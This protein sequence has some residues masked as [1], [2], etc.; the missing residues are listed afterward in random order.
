MTHKQIA[1]FIFVSLF[2][3]SCGKDQKVHEI[4]ISYPL[5][6]DSEYADYK[7]FTV[8]ALYPENDED[9][10]TNFSLLVFTD[11]DD[12]PEIEKLLQKS[13]MVS[14]EEGFEFSA[15]GSRSLSIVYGIYGSNRYGVSLPVTGL[16]E[17][18]VYHV[19]AMA[20]DITDSAY[21]FYPLATKKTYKTTEFQKRIESIKSEQ[22]EDNFYLFDNG[23]AFLNSS[24][25]FQYDI[26]DEEIISIAQRYSFDLNINSAVSLNSLGYTLYEQKK[27]EDAKTVLRKAC[28]TSGPYKYA[29]YNLACVLALLNQ[30]G[31]AISPNELIFHL[32]YSGYLDITYFDKM[33]EDA[34][35]ES[36]RDEEYYKEFVDIIDHAR[37][38]YNGRIYQT[39]GDTSGDLLSRNRLSIHYNSR[40]IYITHANEVVNNDV[41]D[42]VF[43]TNKWW[44]ETPFGRGKAVFFTSFY[45]EG[46]FAEYKGFF[47]YLLTCYGLLIRIP[48][49]PMSYNWDGSEL[50]AW[51]EFPN[52]SKIIFRASLSSGMKYLYYY[53]LFTG[54]PHPIIGTM[55]KKDPEYEFYDFDEIW[56][57]SE[58]NI[59]FIGR[60]QNDA[61]RE[62][63]INL[64]GSNLTLVPNGRVVYRFTD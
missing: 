61:G 32:Q 49:E 62:Y 53:D 18:T 22:K 42:D 15:Q 11:P 54:E 31:R 38:D 55:Y 44:D 9:Q 60:I 13:A 29:H 8:A 51:Q 19:K 45:P 14:S 37:F 35:L 40:E 6:I 25:N 43:V 1:V 27:Y 34:D 17:D 59:G 30:H 33:R 57:N 26:P 16:R 5:F 50:Y 36:I 58:N 20:Y 41:R 4:I 2:F 7:R 23:I 63:S 52:P 46:H 21:A 10:S 39:Y 56:F 64:D 3:V 28:V 47:K 24:D 12:E 48:T